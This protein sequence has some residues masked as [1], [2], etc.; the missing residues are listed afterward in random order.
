MFENADNPPLEIVANPDMTGN[1]SAT[2][3]KF[4]ARVDGEFFA[5]AQTFHPGAGNDPGVADIGPFTFDSTNSVVKVWVWKPVISEVRMQFVNTTDGA[6][7]PLSVSN[8]KINEWEQLTFD[9]TSFIG[10]TGFVDTDRLVIFPDWNTA[11]RTSENI[12]YFD[13]ITF[14]AFEEPPPP[15][16]PMELAISNGGFETGDLTDWTGGGTVGAPG[17]GANTGDFAV[18]LSGGG[19]GEIRQTY[20]A[21]E[22]D[23]INFSVYMLTEGALPTGATFGLAKIV[24]Q[25]A[26]GNDLDP[27]SASIGTLITGDNPGVESTPFL[28]D[29]STPNTWVFSEAQGVAPAGTAQVALLLLNIDFAGGVNNMWFDDAAASLVGDEPP[30]PPPMELA[31]SNGGFETGD[32]TDWTGGGTVGAPGVGANTGD[33]AVE[34]PGG[35]VGEIRQTY[36]AAEGDEINFS[37]YMLTEGAL[38]T[39][40][41]FGLAKI[42]FQDAAGNDLDPASASIGTLI[43]GDNPGVESTPFLNDASTPNTWVFSEAQGVAPAGTAQVAL[44]LLNIDFAGG[45][46]NMWF[47]DAAAS[48]VG[49]EPP[50]PPPMELAISNGGFETGD[51]TDW[52]G[53]GTVGAPGVGAN[54]GD[55]AVELP[56]GGVGEIRQTYDAAEGDEINFSVYML[57]EGALPTGATFGLAKIVFQ[58]AAG[59]DLD[60]ASASIGTL[61]TGDNPGVESTPFLNDASTPNTWVFSEA[62]GVAPA[63][64]AQVALLLLNID[65]AGGVNNMWFDDAA[66]SLV[67]DEPPP[68]PPMELAIS[69]GG[70]ETGDLTDWTGGGTVGA[71][72]VG[73]NTGDFA[74]ELPGGG[75]GEI[76][77]TF[78]AIPGDE[79]NLSV[80]M[81]TEGALP[82]GATF[83]LAKIVFQDA[84][85][86]DLDPASASIGTLITGDN[87]GVES[88]PFL[89]DA[90]TPNTWVFSEAQGVAPAGTAKVVFLLLNIDFAGGVNNMWFDDAAASL[91]TAGEPPPPPPMALAIGN[92]GFETGDLTDWTGGGTVGAPGFGARTGAF[93]AQLTTSGGNG[94]GEIRQTFD[95]A[96]GDEI[97]F[98]AWMLTE[99]ALPTGATF[100]LAK[101][102]FQ[103]A[104]GNDLVPESAS[105]GVLNTDN[106]GIDSAPTL[107][108][109]S[110]PNTWVFTEAQ[111]VAP[112]G[113][114]Q[115]AFLLLNVDFAGGENPMWF[116]DAAAS[117]V[118][119][120]GGGE[121][122]ELTTNGDFEGSPGTLDCWDIFPGG[123]TITAESTEN[124]TVGDFE[125][126]VGSV[127]DNPDATGIN[128]SAKVGQMQ[129]FA[130]AVFGGTT[131]TLDAAETLAAGDSY[132][133]KV[134]ASRAVPVLFKLEGGAVGEVEVNHSGS[135]TWEELCFD[136]TGIAGN[137][138]GITL[139]FDIGTAGA[140]GTDPD[141]WTFQ[142][143]DIQQVTS[144]PTGGGGWW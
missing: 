69:N 83:G 42:V 70:F 35:G 41:T 142:F 125:G 57:T 141:N 81:L 16:P 25:D 92:G 51:L 13:E 71:P 4:T 65:F 10:T 8:T 118:D 80:W 7:E 137:V 72:G 84:A 56:G 124:N 94:V 46:N 40:A 43:T 108:D 133:M 66:A 53:G 97:N 1:T 103:D 93:A 101:I 39:G 59:N 62:Q 122:G 138:S 112:A 86:N 98:S 22:G 130:G 45:V 107:N 5:G 109:T 55:F 20:D 12:I 47:D 75:V 116:D 115:V 89:N 110:T 50:P 88:T 19:V 67:G 135:G 143:D 117:L 82:T 21:A 119:A 139:I 15:P 61:I 85:G 18:E 76:R 77:Q 121:G 60:P 120:C 58:D 105:I 27:A 132:T 126:G 33:F 32:L 106:P 17:V 49:D 23:E 73:A 36:D 90:S 29:A 95:A 63:G 136:F 37:V 24:F 74:V 54:T 2:V 144:C 114:T 134:R 123:G 140:A 127:I 111:G 3:A 26:A 99:N 38:P 11:G 91:V 79:V 64:T 129:K 102:I 14:G 128:T 34:L 6:Q 96:P 113:T 30:P 31:I 104:G 9:F 131:L 44:L 28:N 68:P 87:P 52:T 48:L 100:G 78:D